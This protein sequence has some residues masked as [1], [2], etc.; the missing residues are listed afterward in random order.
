MKKMIF[1]LIL[2]TQTTLFAYDGMNEY[3]QSNSSLKIEK[4]FLSIKVKSSSA[5]NKYLSP[6]VVKT[7]E[8]ISQLQ[9]SYNLESSLGSM[10]II[11]K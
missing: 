2:L 3:L 1:T 10:K 6:T 5:T 8:R 11:F 7:L 4:E 9:L